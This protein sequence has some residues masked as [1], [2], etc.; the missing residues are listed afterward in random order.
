MIEAPGTAPV[1][2]EHPVPRPGPGEVLVAVS[3]A[4]VVP[5]DKLCASGTS[6]FGTPAVPYV[7]GVQGVGVVADG[8]PALPVGHPGL[9]RHHRGDG[10]GRRQH[11][12]PRGGGRARRRGAAAGCGPGAGRGA[13]AVRRR[14]V[15]G[16][17]LPRRPG[18]GGAGARAGRR[19][20][21]RA[22]RRAA[23]PLRGGR[24]GGRRGPVGAGP[25]A[26]AG[27]RCG[28]RRRARHRRRRRWPSRPGGGARTGRSTS[29]STRCSACPPPRPCARWARTD[30]WSTWAAPPRR[31]PRWTR[32]R[33]AAARCRC[34]ATPTTS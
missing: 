19:R 24:A 32:R 5:L 8:T 26:G 33:C 28:R 21:R 3:A 6:Y 31:R 12:R 22:G 10:A 27:V 4:P 13:R 25:G 23:R 18:G 29:S 2:R 11:A 7:P 20:R 16:A 1:L 15:D 30:A 17:D 9:V 34:S 14:G